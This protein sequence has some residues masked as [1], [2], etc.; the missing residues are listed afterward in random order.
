[1]KQDAGTHD[2]SHQTEEPDELETL[3]SGSGGGQEGAIPLA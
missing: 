1:M 3:M 2:K